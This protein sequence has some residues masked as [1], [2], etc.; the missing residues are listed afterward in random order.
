M[1][2]APAIVTARQ[3][4][5]SEE[6]TPCSSAGCGRSARRLVGFRRLLGRLKDRT[7][8]QFVQNR[9]VG[10]RAPS[11]RIVL[12]ELPEKVEVAIHKALA[13]DPMERFGSAREFV[14]QLS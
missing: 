2:H 5:C 7:H 8:I 10:E 3:R 6:P 13:K 11:L 14:S 9:H 4:G 1:R 12:P